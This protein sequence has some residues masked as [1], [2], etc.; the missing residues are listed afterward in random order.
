MT[1]I[2][3]GMP[4]PVRHKSMPSTSIQACWVP[5]LLPPLLYTPRA[6]LM[7]LRAIADKLFFSLYYSLG[8]F[9]AIVER[10]ERDYL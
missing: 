1:R 5:A 7:P 6:L 8:G 4:T 10:H 3:R 9:R 2:P